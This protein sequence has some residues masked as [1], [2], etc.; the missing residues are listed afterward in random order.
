MNWRVS[1]MIGYVMSVVIG[2]VSVDDVV[3]C[4]VGLQQTCALIL[5]YTL[6]GNQSRMSWNVRGHCWKCVE[7]SK[8]DGE[9]EIGGLPA[10][11]TSFGRQKLLRIYLIFLHLFNP[12][13]C[14]G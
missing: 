11:S 14:S 5:L 3:V 4:Y 13:W 1:D 8:V 2:V 9:V 10:G 7:Q 12:I 6:P